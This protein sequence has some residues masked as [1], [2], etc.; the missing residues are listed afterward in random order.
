MP[1]RGIDIICDRFLDGL[2]NVRYVRLRV[3]DVSLTIQDVYNSLCD[4]SWVN[5]L[6]VYSS[7]KD[8]YR[9]RVTQT[10]E[11]IKDDFQNGNGVIDA[12]TGEYV[13]SESA[14]RYLVDQ[15]HYMDIP[16]A[17]LMKQRI[18]GNQGFDFFSMNMNEVLLFG[19]AKYRGNGDESGSSEALGQI[20]EFVF[21]DAPRDVSDIA[22][23]QAFLTEAA[24]RNF[25]E[26]QKGYVAAFTTW[27]ESDEHVIRRITQHP[28]FASLTQFPELICVAI[29]VAS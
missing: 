11:R 19:E 5:R 8:A 16:L 14:R 1:L 25:R 21:G 15:L 3:T 10:S 6:T 26:N 7:V 2:P 4:A 18:I 29:Q 20:H 27:Q 9:L 24:D 22:E 12:D 13:V 23:L 17:E 28:D